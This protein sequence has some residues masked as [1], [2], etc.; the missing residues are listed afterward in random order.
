MGAK[1]TVKERKILFLTVT[2]D[3]LYGYT[4]QILPLNRIKAS[5]QVLNRDFSIWEKESTAVFLRP[6][7]SKCAQDLSIPGF[8]AKIRTE[9]RPKHR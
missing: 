8:C 2:L 7:K 3:F 4:M 6:M 1:S 5:D 9:N